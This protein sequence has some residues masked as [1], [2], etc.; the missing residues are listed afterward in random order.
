MVVLSRKNVSV[1]GPMAATFV[2]SP[3]VWRGVDVVEVN[4]KCFSSDGR[5]NSADDGAKN[6]IHQGDASVEMRI[7]QMYRQGPLTVG[8]LYCLRKS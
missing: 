6:T 4:T 1:V 8:S 2:C 7:I 5:T 3:S